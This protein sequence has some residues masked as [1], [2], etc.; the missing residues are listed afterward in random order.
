MPQPQPQDHLNYRDRYADALDLGER[1]QQEYI[2]YELFDNEP[3]QQMV[4]MPGEGQYQFTTPIASQV[5][6]GNPT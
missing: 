2:D 4:W 3:A 6:L 1:P 5:F